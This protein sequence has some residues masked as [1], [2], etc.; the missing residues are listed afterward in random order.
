[1][2]C[3]FSTAW[4]VT[5]LRGVELESESDLELDGGL[6]LVPRNETLLAAREHL[7]LAQV[8]YDDIGRAPWFL[9]L[10][11]PQPAYQ[12]ADLTACVES[13]QDA[14]MAFQVVKPVETYGFIFQGI[15]EDDSSVRWGSTNIRLPMSAGSWSR[16]RAFDE[17]LLGD[18]RSMLG[19]LREAMNGSDIGKRNAVHLLQLALEHTH[20]YVA[21]LLAV[22]GIEAVL[23][24]GGKKQFKKDLCGLLGSSTLAFPDWNSPGFR[25]L[26]YTV[27][28]LAGPLYTLRSKIAH[29]ANLTR[30][31]FDRNSPL[32]LM[33]A[34]EYI[35]GADP[36][37]YAHL[38]SESS[39]YLLGQVLQKV[40]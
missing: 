5:P 10:R 9:V 27:R 18:A 17:R 29:G 20:P 22:T 32:D 34:K 19:R 40:L 28:E 8:Q 37:V 25:P 2:S 23:Q 36:V 15:Q 11:T 39:I 4:T 3:P 26:K 1:M 16:I 31:S 14:L 21:C 38:L 33:Q 24:S 7:Y 35:D 13:L 6:A 30:S 12:F